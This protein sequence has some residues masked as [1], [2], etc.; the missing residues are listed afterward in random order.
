MVIGN[1]GLARQLKMEAIANLRNRQDS[2]DALAMAQAGLGWVEGLLGNLTEAD[3]LSHEAISTNQDHHYVEPLIIALRVRGN[4]AL[5]RGQYVPAAGFLKEALQV[6]HLSSISHL[7]GSVLVSLAKIAA[8]QGD[9][10]RSATLFG[11]LDALWDRLGFSRGARRMLS[12]YDE[13]FEPSAE[14]M[15]DAGYRQAF[16]KGR[17][18]R[19]AEAFAQGMGVSVAATPT[20]GNK[21]L[22][23]RRETEVLAHLAQ[24]KTN[25]QIAAELFVGK[26]TVDTH[27]A[28]ILTKLD[29]ESRLAAVQAARERGL[30]PQ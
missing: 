13:F 29:V 21:A 24:G 2:P 23:T 3:Q 11:Y 7:E 8:S 4:V 20:A 25:Q 15:A 12:S 10:W 30:L 14:T 18:L 6:A 16:E 27:V 9:W 22:L 26:S 1:L 28:H 19:Y 5:E 17:N